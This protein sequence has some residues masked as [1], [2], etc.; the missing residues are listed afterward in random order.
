MDHVPLF[1]FNTQLCLCKHLCF[2]RLNMT[3]N[4]AFPLLTLFFPIHSLWFKKSFTRA[5][6]SWKWK[7]ILLLFQCIIK[8]LFFLF[9]LCCCMKRSVST[10]THTRKH[11]RQL[12]IITI[13]YVAF[14]YKKGPLSTKHGRDEGN[15]NK[16]KY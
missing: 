13:K 15:E 3:L 10:S 9:F 7:K 5:F 6:I 16:E 2:F 8:I 14:V 1:L 11:K 4:N 12:E